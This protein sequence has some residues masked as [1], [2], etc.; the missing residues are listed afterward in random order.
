MAL[1]RCGGGELEFKKYALFAG[2]VNAS[3]AIIAYDNGSGETFT[4]VEIS[5]ANNSSDLFTAQYVAPNYVITFKQACNVVGGYGTTSVTGSKAVGDTIN[6]PR[7]GDT[8]IFAYT[9]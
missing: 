1:F 3:N 4:D 6:M 5:S 8:A 7:S 9:V 2:R